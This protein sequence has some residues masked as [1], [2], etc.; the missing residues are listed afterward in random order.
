MPLPPLLS[1]ADAER[2]GPHFRGSLAPLRSR[3]FA[4][5]LAGA[6]T[7]YTGRWIELT[8]TVWLL[9]ELTTSPV[10]LG[11]LG[12]FRAAPT[13]IL[14]P[15]AGVIVDRVDRRRLL[16]S[17]QVLGFAASTALA[18]LVISGRV[19]IWHVY[20]QLMMQGV[21]EAFDYTIRQAL[22]PDLVG[23]AQRAE[24]IT[25]NTTAGRA[26]KF[27]GP[28]VA[29]ILIARVH[30]AAPFVVN[31][32]SFVALAMVALVMRIPRPEPRDRHP[33]RHEIVAGMSHLI[34][35][36]VLRGLVQMEIAFAL[37]A[38]NPVAIT[39]VARDVMGVGPEGLGALLAAPGLG[40]L[41]GLVVLL[42][43]GHPG[44]QGRFVVLC[45]LGYAVAL[46]GLALARDVP[47][48]LVFLFAAGVFDVLVTVTRWSVIHFTVPSEMRGRMVANVLSVTNG[49][50][51]LG[52]TQSGV[53]I[54]SLGAPIALLT[55]SVALGA[56]ALTTAVANRPLWLFSREMPELEI[57]AT[58]A[59]P[60]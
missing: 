16:V 12:L 26:A 22:L 32:C 15:L 44:R 31:A 29:G 56:T 25:L 17:T 21:V 45:T 35:T 40:A 43:V 5:Y 60:A 11:L 7:S 47:P 53:L 33:F 23:H 55:A 19:E 10:L 58:S 18:L 3:D 2:S 51:Q 4:L 14:G 48:A 28:L 46:A 9:S 57:A 1:R 41:F 30:T 8:G 49:L 20:I 34:R 27:V 38:V 50:N 42:A 52:Q 36:P 24:A 6:G 37:L 39:I 13:V 54:G 59:P